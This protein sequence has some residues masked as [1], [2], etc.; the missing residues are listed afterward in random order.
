MIGAAAERRQ[1]WLIAAALSLLIH[2][3]LAVWLFDLWPQARPPL[4]DEGGGPLP[5]IRIT[6]LTLPDNVPPPDAPG[7]AIP[8]GGPMPPAE[9]VT[10]LPPDAPDAAPPNA[11]PMPELAGGAAVDPTPQTPPALDSAGG[12]AP[13]AAPPALSPAEAEAAATLPATPPEPEPKPVPEPE[14]SGSSAQL[15]DPVAP[16]LV[17]PVGPAVA[18][19][20]P[21][22]PPES[23]AGADLPTPAP[24]SA[25]APG[26]GIDIVTAPTVDSGTSGAAAAV[27]PTPEL[28]ALGDMLRRI[29]ADLGQG[30]LLALPQRLSET[31]LGLTVLA[32]T[33]RGMGTM[34]EN[35]TQGLN[36][37]VTTRTVLVDR[38]QCPAVAFLRAQPSYP[39]FG[40]G[41]GVEATSV[42]SG[43][44]IRGQIA[45]AAPGQSVTLL[46]VD[47]GGV[48]QDLG[49]F[50][51][52]D[53]GRAS[54]DIPVRRDGAA[55]D[56]G[57][58]LIALATPRRPRAVG[59]HA[60]KLAAEFFPAL[61]AELERSGATVAVVSVDIR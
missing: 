37:P 52:F 60:D 57:Q 29:R 17:A 35:V 21:A 34:V 16:G 36:V 24:G 7:L 47:D 48:V 44:S 26:T 11:P 14:P 42:V 5:E 15:I 3:A 27:A 18:P 33:D 28:R 46:F 23:A 53:G 55:R 22:A 25:A 13:A 20:A 12:P 59:D 19:A 9:T 4:P 54:F 6:A 58:L 61:T 10:S 30:C 1:D 8:P 50:V 41:L 39:A 38:A 56:T 43:A 40:L 2:V 49:R 32:D 51:S 31:E 45:G